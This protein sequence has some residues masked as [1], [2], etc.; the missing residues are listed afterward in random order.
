MV[1]FWIE[2]GVTKMVA[3]WFEEALWIR[4]KAEGRNSGKI[5]FLLDRT[6]S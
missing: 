1:L 4:G 5:V 6:N 3:L 2:K